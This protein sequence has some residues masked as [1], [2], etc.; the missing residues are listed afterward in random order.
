MFNSKDDFLKRAT[1]T[2]T[3]WNWDVVCSNGYG[4]WQMN[5]KQDR[6][7]RWS[8]ALFKGP[9]PPGMCVLHACDNRRC[10]NPDHLS[11]GTIKENLEQMT[12]RGR[13]AMGDKVA[14][15]GERSAAAKIG[16]PQANKIKSL[17]SNGLPIIKIVRKMGLPY[18][19]V[20]RVYHG[21][22]WVRP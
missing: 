1:K 20:S 7:H 17:K 15:R 21:K 3:C 14:N 8:Y 22:T 10:V 13:R 18:G 9:I 11:I 4:H 12:E 5:K 2:K 16:W 19:I 6:A